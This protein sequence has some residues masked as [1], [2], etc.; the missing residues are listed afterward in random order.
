MQTN[1]TPLNQAKLWMEALWAPDDLVEFRCLARGSIFSQEWVKF[2]A[3]EATLVALQRKQGSPAHFTIYAGV[4]PRKNS[5]PKDAPEETLRGD[6]N[7]TLA[8]SVYVDFDKDLNGNEGCSVEQAKSRISD[9]NLPSASM[10]IRTPKGVHAYWLLEE[11]LTDLDRFRSIQKYLARKLNTDT[12]ITNPER[13]MRVPGFECDK[14]HGLFCELVEL[15]SDQKYPVM[16]FLQHHDNEIKNT[17]TDLENKPSALKFTDTLAHSFDNDP[18]SLDRIRAS[19]YDAGYALKR[20]DSHGGI[21]RWLRPGGHSDSDTVL[22]TKMSHGGGRFKPGRVY[23]H[24]PDGILDSGRMLQPFEAWMVL[25]HRGNEHQARQALIT[26][27]V[28]LRDAPQDEISETTLLAEGS[29]QLDR[30]FHNFS[31]TQGRDVAGVNTPS[32]PGMAGLLC[33]L[34]GFCLLTGATGVGKTTFTYCLAL[35]AAERTDAKVVY[36][37]AEMQVDRLLQ[38]LFSQMSGISHRKL[39]L[40]QSEFTKDEKRRFEEAKN[41]LKK[42]LGTKLFILGRE[43]FGE[44]TW[45]RSRGDH[46]LSGLQ[47]AVN[48]RVKDASEV[49]VVIDSLATLDIRPSDGDRNHV[50]DLSVDR[51]IT[52]A[53]KQWRNE[54]GPLHC[55]LAIHEENKSDT[56][57]T[58]QQSVRGS[59]RYAYMADVRLS[60]LEATSKEGSRTIGQRPNPPQE[61]VTEVDLHVTKSRDGEHGVVMLEH[62]FKLSTVTELGLITNHQAHIHEHSE[63]QRLDSLARNGKTAAVRE[64]ARLDLEAK[65]SS[66]LI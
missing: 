9:G 45:S 24:S 14:R 65:K 57:T 32:F 51:D 52:T 7:I 25:R 22:F 33:G 27:G 28:E 37:S 40:K 62:R 38:R 48:S 31:L 53:L 19:L 16:E 29:S 20:S 36:V 2:E 12:A 58:K 23:A 26:E 30:A 59:S 34:S 39:R 61:D 49:L 6:R 56:G 66:R 35:D 15:H 50:E 43:E 47:K 54:L 55:V 60:M 42:I 3:I 10:L 21:E 13:I 41:R 5:V 44:L 4:N 8:R 63:M 1:S 17:I 18:A 46:C 11:P 64:Q